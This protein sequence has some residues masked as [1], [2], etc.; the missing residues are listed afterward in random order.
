MLSPQR[1][2]ANRR[3]SRLST[4]PRTALGKSASSA[5]A[6]KTGIHSNRLLHPSEDPRELDA[7]SRAWRST[8]PNPAPAESTLV[9][10][11]IR[12]SWLLNR[13]ARI[14][15]GLKADDA[16][17]A[18]R[19]AVNIL[20]SP[21]IGDRRRS[22]EP[23]AAAARNDRFLQIARRRKAVFKDFQ[24][25]ENE[26]KKLRANRQ[27]Q[28]VAPAQPQQN[29]SPAAATGPFFRVHISPETIGPVAE[30]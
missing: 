4:G 27:A 16:A 1:L 29:I 12:C 5:N 2:A 18:L 10:T 13:L 8:Y 17:S 6:L 3:N 9:D 25:A 22:R 20:C 19:S 23:R 7:V 14:E 24:N 11:L 28:S 30:L 26:L 15:S 21:Q